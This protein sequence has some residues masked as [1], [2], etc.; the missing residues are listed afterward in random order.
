MESVRG[1][2]SAGK[3]RVVCAIAPAGTESFA[4][5]SLRRGGAAAMRLEP[6]VPQ[7]EEAGGEK[8]GRNASQRTLERA[9]FW[10]FV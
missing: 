3:E 6:E 7:Q 4:V 2:E 10:A 1:G 8:Q 9:L 5:N